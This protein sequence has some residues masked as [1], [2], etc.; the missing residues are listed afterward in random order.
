MRPFLFYDEIRFTGFLSSFY[1]INLITTNNGFK[2]FVQNKERNMLTLFIIAAILIFLLAPY[3][4]DGIIEY[5][6][7]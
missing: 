6:R 5:K 3:V 2:A 4:A 7:S 1:I